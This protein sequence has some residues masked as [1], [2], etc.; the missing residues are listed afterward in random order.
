MRAMEIYKDR[1]IDY[2]MGNFCTY[3]MFSL[4]GPQ[5]LSAVLQITIGLDGKFIGA[6]I[7]PA[8][9]EGRGGPVPDPSG[10]VIKKVQS[11]STTDFPTTSPKIAD[12]GTVTP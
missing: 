7:I 2:S 6:K 4:N 12:D 10:A 11:L 3:G 8:K 9:Q 1:L 5:S